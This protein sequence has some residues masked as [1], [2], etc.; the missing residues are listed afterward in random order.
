V[1][2]NNR[3]NDGIKEMEMFSVYLTKCVAAPWNLHFE[4]I[5]FILGF[6]ERIFGFLFWR[7]ILSFAYWVFRTVH[8][9]IIASI[10]GTK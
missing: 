2:N 5:A 7:E 3:N 6:F 4:R 8:Q 1:W 10:P 9:N